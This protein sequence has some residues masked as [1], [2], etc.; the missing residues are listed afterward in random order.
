[1][2]IS[3]Q[4]SLTDFLAY[5]FPG[6]FSTLGLYL[7]VRLTPLSS[8]LNALPSD[9]TSGLIFLA[10]SYILGV[11][12]SGFSMSLTEWMEK[13]QKHQDVWDTLQPEQFQEE[14]LH[15]FRDVFNPGKENGIQWSREHFYLCRSLVIEKM[16]VVAQRAERQSS[17][18]Q[19]R[20][21]LIFPILIWFIVGVAW[22]LNT[23]NQGKPDW[24]ISLIILSALVS[25]FTLWATIARMYNNEKRE[26]RRFLIAFLAGYKAG[27]FENESKK[28][29]SNIVLRRVRAQ[30]GVSQMRASAQER[31]IAGMTKSEIESEIQLARQGRKKQKSVKK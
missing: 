19:I 20:R 1:M 22:G 11:I 31:G 14:L 5:F 30:V 10:L 26:V 6:L 8:S 7:L 15:A 2:D 28:K 23:I 27:I 12:F 29:P 9:L 25:F 17:L 21:N 16:P 24:G 18:R 3:K 4:F 13:I